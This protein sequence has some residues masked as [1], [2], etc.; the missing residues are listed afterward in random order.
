MP[1]ETN[2][3]LATFYAAISR[4]NST[5]QSPHGPDGWFP[6]QK[7]TRKEALKGMTSVD[8]L[9]VRTPL[10]WIKGMTLDAAYASFSENTVGSLVV[11]KKADYVVLSQD[12]MTV[13]EMLQILETS[14]IATVVDGRVMYGAL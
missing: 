1:I 11:G 12:I 8:A 14:V 2:N 6:E 7:L 9:A 10:I 3:P 13:P 4:L 5:G